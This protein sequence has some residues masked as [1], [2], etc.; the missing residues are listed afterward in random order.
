MKAKLPI[1]IV[2]LIALFL[3]LYQLGSLPVS[4]FGD[5]VDVGYHAWSLAT[6]LRD[7]RGN[8][9]PTYI[10]SLSEARAP[11]LMYLTAP[12]VGL[13]GPSNFSVRLPSA[14]MG[15]ASLYLVYLVTNLLFG[16]KKL[17]PQ[18]WPNGLPWGEIDIGLVAAI[19]LA[20]APWHLHYSRSAFELT[21]L[22]FLTLLGVY[23]YLRGRQETKYLRLFLLP[24]V[25][26]FYT[27]STANLFTPFLLV[28]LLFLFPPDLK[29]V[30]NRGT[31]LSLIV[32][33]LLFLPILYHL[34]FGAAVG[35]FRLI[36][37]FSDQKSIDQIIIDR[38]RPWVANPT[39]EKIF[40]N[41]AATFLAAFGNNY[42][43]SFSTEFLFIS[44]DPNFRQ[45]VS[46]F[47]ELLVIFAP[48][49]LAGLIIVGRDLKNRASL[50]LLLWLLFVPVASSLTIAGGNHA[51]RLF[52]MLFPLSVLI[53][54]GFIEGLS[55]I[56]NKKLVS[57]IVLSTLIGLLVNFAAYWYRYSAHYRYESAR[58]WQYGYE[59]L[60]KQ[61]RPYLDRP[62]RVF[63]N[64]TYDPAL[65][66]FAFY[67]KL[68]PRDFQKMFAGD[69]PTE[70]L[71]PGFNGFQFGD[72][73]FFGRAATL[74]AMQ[75]LLR[76]GDLY[77]A[78]QGEEIP[79]DWDWSQSPPAGIKAL[80]TVRNFYGQ[81][82]M[83]VL[84]KVR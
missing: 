61:A 48:F 84:E 56:K 41:K 50:F 31:A 78:V 72:R 37:I 57:L 25:L 77:L 62:G 30:K 23:W 32:S 3:R 1:I 66:R 67:T 39:L 20:F 80:A 15:V 65:Y 35:R 12:F 24:F 55:L 13:F 26:T 38:T 10:Q 17:T 63:I 51:S 82:L 70:N 52:L 6:T 14:L 7:Y 68:P 40:H 43:T 9:L 81:P 75:N 47:G 69:I 11:L 60:M 27:Y 19:V 49:L 18:G 21:T 28:L 34:T 53:A 42:L 83:Y 33:L 8:F 54:V 22:F 2:L 64:N 44:G 74:E 73:F 76:P 46:R 79:G 4:L 36:N 45:S 16:K 5:E 29:K 59:S 71:L 58:V